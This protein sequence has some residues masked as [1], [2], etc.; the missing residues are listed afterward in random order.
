M[1][2]L[3]LVC[4]FIFRALLARRDIFI[5]CNQLDVY[6]RGMLNLQN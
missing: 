2:T 3:M 1:L 6:Q 5:I 4:V